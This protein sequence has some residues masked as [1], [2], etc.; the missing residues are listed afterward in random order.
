M[1][2]QLSVTDI[3]QDLKKGRAEETVAY[4]LTLPSDV[5]AI[6]VS[7]LDLQSI[8]ALCSANKAFR[9]WC[10]TDS[11]GLWQ[12]VFD[13]RFKD[14]TIA[15]L[16]KIMRAYISDSLE[17]E[18]NR[19]LTIA[20]NLIMVPNMTE[21]IVFNKFR[22]FVPDDD[23]FFNA[24]LYS[25]DSND[26]FID[27]IFID[28]FGGSV[29]LEEMDLYSI[30]PYLMS[31]L[32]PAL[33]DETRV[34]ISNFLFLFL[35]FFK[36]RNIGVT[37]EAIYDDW[38]RVIVRFQEL[39]AWESDKLFSYG[40]KFY[41]FYT[42]LITYAAIQASEQIPGLVFLES[43]PDTMSEFRT[44]KAKCFMC[45]NKAVGR[46][47]KVQYCSTKCQQQDWPQ[48]QKNHY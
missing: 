11:R 16:K 30:Q 25:S 19:I 1:K 35:K 3:E 7:Q 46:C 9:A 2:R 10:D 38:D 4:L 31:I 14:I 43:D 15:K 5:R 27:D 32:K 42:L 17:L 29:R 8:F 48:H 21:T 47:C 39:G 6:I 26:I 45:P 12:M 33:G 34:I 44:V 13:N 24:E 20:Y 36:D 37:L 23:H 41:K 22:F 18:N 40:L 28:D